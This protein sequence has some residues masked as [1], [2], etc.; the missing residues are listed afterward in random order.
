[1]YKRVKIKKL[2]R[3]RSHRDALRKNQLRSLFTMGYLTTTDVK[4]KV[5]KM[6]ADR[7]VGKIRRAKNDLVLTR[8]LT[9][10][11][12]VRTL[13]EAAVKYA[14][15]GGAV[16]RIMKVGFRDGD[17]AL[18]SKI[19]LVGYEPVKKPAKT[20]RKKAKAEAKAQK[21][22][23]SKD[24]EVHAKKAKPKGLGATIRDAFTGRQDRARSRSG[25]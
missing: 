9:T 1:M 15:S 2:G 14:K 10:D 24:P 18:V 21:P 19:E 4:A 11:L 3:T 20:K 25:I 7:L 22:E 8:E 13:V 16:T 17:N 12:G 5:L 23:V 6:N